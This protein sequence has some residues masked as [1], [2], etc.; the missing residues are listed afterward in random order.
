MARRILEGR[1]RE[2]FFFSY[3]DALLHLPKPLPRV[4]FILIPNRGKSQQCLEC[5]PIERNIFHEWIPLRLDLSHSRRETSFSCAEGP[6]TVLKELMVK[7]S[8]E[9]VV[10]R[11]WG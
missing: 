2:R 6:L 11:Q 3:A 4:I 1:R 7:V 10:L 9:T 5:R 8:K